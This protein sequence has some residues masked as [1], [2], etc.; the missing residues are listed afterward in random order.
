MEQNLRY[1]MNTLEQMR[2]TIELLIAKPL[3]HEIDV[4]RLAA[5][6]R[7]LRDQISTAISEGLKKFDPHT[8]AQDSL[9]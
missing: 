6:H 3:N 2:A 9:K 1:H 4:I 7:Q 8:Y 5:D